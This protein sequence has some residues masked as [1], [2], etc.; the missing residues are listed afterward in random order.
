MNGGMFL[1][2]PVMLSRMTRTKNNRRDADQESSSDLLL[3]VGLGDVGAES[4][5]RFME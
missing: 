5:W 4:E 1:T 2:A 3:I